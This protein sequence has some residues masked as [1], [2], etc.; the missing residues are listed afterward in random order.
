MNRYFHTQQ[1]NDLVLQYSTQ[2]VDSDV[3]VKQLNRVLIC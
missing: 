3:Y 1:L 2:K